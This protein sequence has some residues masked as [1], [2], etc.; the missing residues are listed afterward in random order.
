[1]GICSETLRKWPPTGIAERRCAKPY[2]IP[3]VLSKEKE[4]EIQAGQTIAVPIASIQMD[5]KYFPD[6]KKFDPERFSDENK[7]NIKSGT[8]L[9]FGMGPRNCIGK[10]ILVSENTVLC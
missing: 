1:M 8:Y 3:P 4:V 9:P 7:H 10:P 5:E 6:P 2:T